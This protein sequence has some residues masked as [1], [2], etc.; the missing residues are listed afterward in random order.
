MYHHDALLKHLRNNPLAMML[1]TQQEQNANMSNDA[2]DDGEEQCDSSANTAYSTSVHSSHCDAPTLTTQ[3]EE[4]RLPTSGIPIPRANSSSLHNNTY[5]S[6]TDGAHLSCSTDDE[7]AFPLVSSF[8]PRQFNNSH[9]QPYHSV[10]LLKE[11]KKS[12]QSRASLRFRRKLEIS[13]IAIP[14]KKSKKQKKPG[15]VDW[16]KIRARVQ[17]LR[18]KKKNAE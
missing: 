5:Y 10:N 12:Q 3:K 6:F 11:L 17:E 9:Y 4:F 8:P 18:M 13:P 2:M 1:R 14:T 16:Q 15:A 7:D